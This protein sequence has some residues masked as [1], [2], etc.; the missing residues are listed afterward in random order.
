MS[1][2]GTQVPD[3]NRTPYGYVPTEAVCITFLVLFAISG[4][5]HLFQAIKYRTWWMIASLVVGCAGEVIGW[6][7][8]L[9]SSQNPGLLDPFLMQ[10]TTTII[11]PSFMSAA[12]FTILGFIIRK[13][14]TQYSWLTPRWYLIIFITLDLASLVVQAIGGARASAAAE[15]DED[16]DPGG[17]IM[18]YGIVAQMIALTAYVILGTEVIV[19]YYLNKP[20]RKAP[21]PQDESVETLGEKKVHSNGRTVLDSNTKLM[22]LGLIVSSVFLFIR[23]IYRT[24]E[25]NDGWDGS[26]ITNQALFNWLDGMPITVCTYTFNIL[27]PGYLLFRKAKGTDTP[28][29]L[30]K[31]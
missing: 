5:L 18:L 13:I 14:G 7:G 25:L 12:N 31:A 2:N 3:P 27:H 15:N 6:S 29:A 22:L 1:S 23:A 17:R 16:A 8:R 4:L 11:S 26:V 19:R 24:I 21:E 20:V 9:W 30:E 28:A 10:I